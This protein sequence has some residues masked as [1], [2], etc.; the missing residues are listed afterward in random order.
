MATVR[1]TGAAQD[2]RQVSTITVSGTWATGDTA[3]LTIN[4]KSLTVTVGSS[5]STTNIADILAR[6]VNAAN[7]TENLL[8]NE[9]RNFGGR[10][11]PEFTEVVATSSGAVLT[12]SSATPGVPFTITRSEPCLPH[13]GR[14]NESPCP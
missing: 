7:A 1:W 6:A 2:V 14:C 8:G 5:T 12:L 9:S 13:R 11:L 4:N 10:E 3:T